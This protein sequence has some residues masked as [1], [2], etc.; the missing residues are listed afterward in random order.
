VKSAAPSE[1]G[2]GST[3]KAWN[4][5]MAKVLRQFDS[6]LIAWAFYALTRLLD[7]ISTSAAIELSGG[8]RSL[9][10]NLVPRLFMTYYGIHLGNALHEIAV[11]GGAILVYI[12]LSEVQRNFILFRLASPRLVP[13]TIGAASTFIVL[14]NLRI[15]FG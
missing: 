15:F 2:S 10:A 9:E 3:A 12:I 11:L 14:H 4:D 13:Y 7:A 8:D 6:A 5:T 1:R